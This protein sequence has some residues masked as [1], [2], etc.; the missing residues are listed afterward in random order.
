MIQSPAIAIP[1]LQGKVSPEEWGV[2]VD[3]AAC[4]RLVALFGWSDLVFTHITAR[5]PGTTDQFLINPYGMLFD[6]I[7]ASSLVKVDFAPGPGGTTRA[8]RVTVGV[9]T[10]G[11]WIAPPVG[12]SDADHARILGRTD[13]SVYAF[14]HEA[15]AAKN[16]D[17]LL[18]DGMHNDRAR[19]R[20][21]A[22]HAITVGDR[23]RAGVGR[24]LHESS[25]QWLAALTL[26]LAE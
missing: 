2:R 24:E 17:K 10:A 26:E 22:L 6:E 8:T 16:V 13:E 7:T 20:R 15:F 14:V 9:A 1:S 3:L 25:A 11:F 12:H 23:E 5:V 21:L 4:Y 18:L 19:L